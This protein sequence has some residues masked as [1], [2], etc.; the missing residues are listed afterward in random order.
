MV[1]ATTYYVSPTGNNSNP[2]TINSPWATWGHAFNSTAVLPGDTVFF[3]GGVYQMTS[4]NLSYPYAPG[5]GYNVSRDG[6]SGNYIS[7]SAYPGEKPV[8]DCGNITP[9]GRNSRAIWG[10]DMNY[11]HFKGLTVRN[12]RQTSA[13]VNVYGWVIEGRNITVEGCTVHNCGGRGFFSTGHEIRYLN[14]DSHHNYDLLSASLPGNDGVGFQ[15]VDLTNVDGSIYYKNCRAWMNGDQDSLPYQSV[16]LSLMAAGPLTMGIFKVKVM[17]LRWG[18][19]G[20]NLP[21][22]DH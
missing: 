14:C 8:L 1:S 15:N 3:R 13:D 5:C 11:I 22:L 20:S 9:T 12:V 7:Y 19:L 18:P 4:D 16:I 17:D 21:R 10:N 6:T 2:G